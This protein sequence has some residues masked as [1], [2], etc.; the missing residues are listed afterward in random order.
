MK[1]KIITLLIFLL[2]NFSKAQTTTSSVYKGVKCLFNDKK[3]MNNIE[4]VLELF[5][6]N[7]NQAVIK[8]LTLLSPIKDCFGINI[9]GLI[10]STLSLQKESNDA[11]LN[12]VKNY[13]APIILRKYI[14]DYA[15]NKGMISAKEECQKITEQ[16]PYISYKNICNLLQ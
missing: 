10:S 12:Q 15:S 4:N 1:S 7:D 9:T 6:S 11:V 13:D 5:F 3:T 14:Y 16:E 2:S 8:V